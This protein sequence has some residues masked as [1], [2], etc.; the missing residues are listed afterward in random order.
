M[1]RGENIEKIKFNCFY[2]PKFLFLEKKGE[3]KWQYPNPVSQL[4]NSDPNSF[5]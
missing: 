4:S 2:A 5:P 1:S 3:S